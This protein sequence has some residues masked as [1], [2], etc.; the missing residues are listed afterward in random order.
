M[1]TP[2]M[3]TE[4]HVKNDLNHDIIPEG[5]FSSTGLSKNLLELAGLAVRK[6]HP[7]VE[8]VLSFPAENGLLIL[9]LRCLMMLHL[10]GL[11]GFLVG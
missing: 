7:F 5:T 4:Q 11:R 6:A 3:S 2:E 9:S 8:S 10:A 1:L